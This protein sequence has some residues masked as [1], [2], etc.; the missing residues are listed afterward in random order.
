MP[1][2]VHIPA[3]R[4]GRLDSRQETLPVLAVSRAGA[5][6]DADAAEPVAALSCLPVD[7]VLQDLAETSFPNDAFAGSPAEAQKILRSFRS[8]AEFFLTAPLPA[9]SAARGELEKPEDYLRN[10]SRTTGLPLESCRANHALLGEVLRGMAE[11]VQAAQLGHTVTFF[12]DHPPRTGEPSH[13]LRTA[14][15]LR[16]FLPGTLPVLN[17]HWLPAVALGAPV[18]LH[19]SPEDP[20]TSWRLVQ[21]LISAGIPSKIFSYAA[22]GGPVR[23]QLGEDYAEVRLDESDFRKPFHAVLISETGL[24][25]WQGNLKFLV[26]ELFHLGGRSAGRPRLVVVPR[27][28]ED[29]VWGLAQRVVKEGPDHRPARLGCLPRSLVSAARVVAGQLQSVVDCGAAVDITAKPRGGGPLQQENGATRFLPVVLHA[30]DPRHPFFQ[31]LHDFPIISVREE[32]DPLKAL[33]LLPRG[34]RVTLIGFDDQQIGKMRAHP[35]IGEL[36]LGRV[37]PDQ[38]PLFPAAHRALIRGLTEQVYCAAADDA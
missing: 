35:A 3:L 17:A 13:F 1:Y 12:E 38:L 30:R 24:E 25:D 19:P 29:M 8:A 34:S 2:P 14:A 22:L 9:P 15:P 5:A 10:V 18:F 21:A 32:R 28:A 11:T 36:R 31:G 26:D 33:A 7:E 37:S 4:F 27:R 20:W 23:Q 6:E 16:V